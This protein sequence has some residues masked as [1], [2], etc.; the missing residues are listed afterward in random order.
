M[1][2][3]TRRAAAVDLSALRTNG[4]STPGNQYGRVFDLS[5]PFSTT[6]T[7]TTPF[8]SNNSNGNFQFP[9]RPVENTPLAPY[10]HLPPP[11]SRDKQALNLP[12]A[13]DNIMTETPSRFAFLPSLSRFTPFLTP[14]LTV[15]SRKE[16]GEEEATPN[17][18]AT[19]KAR[20]RSSPRGNNSK[21]T[22]TSSPRAVKS[23]ASARKTAIKNV[24]L[25]FYRMLCFIYNGIVY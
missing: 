19:V 10:S 23:V 16:N 13:T 25:Y 20:R 2:A 1:M 8:Y 18:V 12:P 22:P 15:G 5:D 3:S 17:I 14:R 6:T 11:P 4:Q 21:T 7:T 9:E 24:P